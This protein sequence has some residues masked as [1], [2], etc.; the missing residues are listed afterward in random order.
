MPSSCF[1]SMCIIHRLPNAEPEKVEEASHWNAN[2]R[3]SL[4]GPWFEAAEKVPGILQQFIVRILSSKDSFL[5]V[6][7]GMEYMYSECKRFRFQ[8]HQSPSRS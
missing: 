5:T 7:I 6:Y 8:R 2:V 3:V 1:L 4:L